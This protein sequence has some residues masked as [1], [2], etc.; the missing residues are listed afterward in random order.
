MTASKSNFLLTQIATLP[1]TA[2]DDLLAVLVR[3]IVG[4]HLRLS[5]RNNVND[6]RPGYPIPLSFYP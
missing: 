6:H 3:Y 1:L 2:T 4:S 5:R